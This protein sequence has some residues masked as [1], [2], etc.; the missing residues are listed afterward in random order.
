MNKRP[1]PERVDQENPE[2]TAED[3]ARAR[4]A[5][6]L[7]SEIFGPRQASQMLKPKRGRPAI[8]KPKEQVS[9]RLDPEIIEAFRS[10]GSGWQTRINKALA[11]W[12]AE[13]DPEELKTA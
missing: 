11:C 4:P 13:H 5:S 10:S 1:D 2:W 9:L 12:L 6:E 3:F 8:A 7:L